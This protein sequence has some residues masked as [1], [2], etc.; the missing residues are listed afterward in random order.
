MGFEPW[1]LAQ[2][3]DTIPLSYTTIVDKVPSQCPFYNWHCKIHTKK[4]FVLLWDLNPGLLHES[5]VLYH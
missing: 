4:S 2:K 3:S 5:L 1:T